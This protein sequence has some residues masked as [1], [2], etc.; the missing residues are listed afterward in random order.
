MVAH[1]VH[2]DADG[3]NAVVA[4]LFKTGAANPLLDTLGTTF[5]QRGTKP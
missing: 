4:I 3:N 5:R 2:A 1:L